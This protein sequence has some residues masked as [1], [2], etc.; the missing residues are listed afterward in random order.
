[1][2]TRKPENLFFGV[3]MRKKKSQLA[4]SSQKKKNTDK[5]E[6]EVKYSQQ[7]FLIFGAQIRQKVALPNSKSWRKFHLFFP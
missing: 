1:M 5:K 2:A 7:S 3:L 6:I 4:K